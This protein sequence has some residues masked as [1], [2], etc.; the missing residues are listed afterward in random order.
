MCIALGWREGFYP[1]FIEL[2]IEV[3]SALKNL[4]GVVLRAV[5]QVNLFV[6][7]STAIEDGVA[8]EVWVTHRCAAH[9]IIREKVLLDGVFV[10]LDF[11]LLREPAI[12]FI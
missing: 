5:P 10:S 4:I 9:G 6:M 2:N 11:K 7:L 1:V 3:I 12:E 8:L